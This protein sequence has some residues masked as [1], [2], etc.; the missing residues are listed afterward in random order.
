MLPLFIVM[1][2]LKFNGK[3]DFMKCTKTHIYYA[4]KN[5]N[6]DASTL[7]NYITNIVDHYQV[8]ISISTQ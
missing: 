4:T 1:M 3:S 7:K 8:N 5:C 2:V 6:G